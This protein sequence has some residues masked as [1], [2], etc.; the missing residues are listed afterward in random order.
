VQGIQRTEMGSWQ[1]AG[2]DEDGSVWFEQVESE[3]DIGDERLTQF[4]AN[5][6]SS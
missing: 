5:G 4:V 3:Q 2:L 1:E 6:E